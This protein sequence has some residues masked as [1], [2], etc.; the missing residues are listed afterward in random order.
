MRK[1]RG[2]R[3]V[4]REDGRRS[5]GGKRMFQRAGRRP[6]GREIDGVADRQAAGANG[7]YEKR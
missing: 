6:D 3:K 7:D 2:G 5:M 4:S 1:L